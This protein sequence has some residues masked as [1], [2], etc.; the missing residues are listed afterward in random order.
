ME[1]TINGTTYTYEGDPDARLLWVI[2]DHFGL[3]ATKYGCGQG[4]CGSCTVHLDKSPIRSCITPVSRAA[5]K[6]VRTLEDLPLSTPEGEVILHPVQ[7]AFLEH[8]VPQCG[9]CMSG[10]MMQAAALLQSNPDPSPED[11]RQAMSNNYCRCGTYQKIAGA[12]ERAIE[13][14]RERG[15]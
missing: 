12:V 9:W 11:I 5:G 10:Q 15:L 4:I 14:A 13:I 7:E 3:T 1:I 6:A 8:Q 2:R